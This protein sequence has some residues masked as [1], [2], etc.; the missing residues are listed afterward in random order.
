MSIMAHSGADR[1][2]QL[3]AITERLTELVQQ[4][5]EDLKKGRLDASSQNWNEKEKLAHAYRLEMNQIQRN[6]ALLDGMGEAQKNRLMDA[7]Q[8][9]QAILGNH[10]MAI[11][12]MKDVTEGL[13]RAVNEEVATARAAPAGYGA[14]GQMMRKTGSGGAGLAADVKA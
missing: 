11:V 6:P 5:I 7:V 9:F 8:T 13:V 4:E 14:S 2:D 12:A 3:L 10:A 1:A